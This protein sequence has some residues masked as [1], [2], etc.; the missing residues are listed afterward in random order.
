[1][2]ASHFKE[3]HINFYDVV[4]R[5][6]FIFLYKF[7]HFDFFVFVLRKVLI[8][9]KVLFLNKFSDILWWI[10]I[11]KYFNWWKTYYVISFSVFFSN[12]SRVTRMLGICPRYFFYS[13][14]SEAFLHLS[15]LCHRSKYLEIKPIKL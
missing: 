15:L 7:I 3:N 12:Y 1:M 11:K 9:S 14:K 10:I 5:T 2:L 4:K 13:V 6:I 8:F